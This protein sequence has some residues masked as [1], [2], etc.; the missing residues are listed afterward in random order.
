MIPNDPLTVKVRDLLHTI[1][2]FLDLLVAVHNTPLGEAYHIMDTLRLMEFLKDMRKEDMFIRYVHQLVNVQLESQNY[3]EAGLSLQLHADLYPWDTTEKVPSLIDPPFPE[4]TAFE[5][6]EALFLEMIKFFEDGKS[7]ENALEAYKELAHQYENIVF[8]Y[9]KLSRCHRAMAK[10]HEDILN[11]DKF[12]PQYFRVAYLGMG[13]PIGLRDRQFIVQG[14][15]WEKLMQFSDR[16]QQQHPSAKIVAS[17]DIDS[18]EGQF[19]HISAVGPEHDLLHS[20]FQRTKVPPN[21]REFL[22]QKRPRSFSSSRPLPGNDMGRPSSWWTEKTIYN[23]AERFPTILRRSEVVSISTVTVSPV[24]NAIE[25]VTSKTR[26]MSNLER[27]YAEMKNGMAEGSNLNPLSMSLTGAVDSPVNGG[28]GGY[29]E[30]IEDEGV[31]LELRNA[32]RLAILDYVGVLKKCLA[33]H[34]RLVASALRPMHDNMMRFFQRNYAAEIAALAPSALPAPAPASPGQW[35]SP[36]YSLSSS[37]PVPLIKG[38]SEDCNQQRPTPLTNGTMS[39]T[40]PS[41]S[42]DTASVVGSTRGRLAGMIFGHHHHHRGPKDGILSITTTATTTPTS[43]SATPTPTTASTANGNQHIHNAPPPQTTSSARS[44]SGSVSTISRTT[45]SRSRSRSKS[46]G[47]RRNNSDAYPP[48][49]MPPHTH[50]HIQE[51]E[52]KSRASTSSGRP[53]G[54]SGSG[55]MERGVGSVRKRFSKL[56]LGKKGSKSSVKEG[57]GGGGGDARGVESVAEE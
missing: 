28:V 35:R 11:G 15:H 22:L 7:W 2:E 4:Q 19:I 44:H 41:I 53:P 18:V 51:Y 55:I 48:P 43:A 31:T 13:F 21:T 25:A 36:T 3:V 42:E 29:R 32:L 57:I 8:D 24:E 16:I 26:E 23:T 49:P 10:I 27:R 1:D 20:V 34:G 30:L 47:R 14:N 37:P 56:G 12:S 45:S 33:V 5:R 50:T 17:G 38:S 40:A 39:N 54:S 6:R 46:A 52:D 9:A